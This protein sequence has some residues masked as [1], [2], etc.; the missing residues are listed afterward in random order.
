MCDCPMLS[1]VEPLLAMFDLDVGNLS[2]LQTC[3]DLYGKDI[4][5]FLNS[6]E[7]NVD[8]VKPREKQVTHPVVVV[9]DDEVR[10]RQLNRIPAHTKTAT[11]WSIGVWTD[12]KVARSE[13]CSE[14]LDKCPADV[15]DITK[16]SKEEIDF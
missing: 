7:A 9:D 8:E 16:I 5:L 13:R 6:C 12:W 3:S 15:G 10:E 1:R 11:M 4:D 2:Q 14:N